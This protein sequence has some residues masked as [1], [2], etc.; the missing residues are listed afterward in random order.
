MG[1]FKNKLLLLCA[2]S[3]CIS[4]LTIGCK[5]SDGGGGGSPAPQTA[6][7]AP[8]ISVDK[9]ADGLWVLSAMTEAGANV[10][11]LPYNE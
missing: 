5:K 4:L 8:T 7:V 11:P 6:P 10:T 3:T 1:L 9:T 2:F